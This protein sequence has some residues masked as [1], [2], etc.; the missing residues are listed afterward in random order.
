MTQ[1]MM[2]GLKIHST[3]PEVL[4][5]LDEWMQMRSAPSMPRPARDWLP[6]PQGWLKANADGAFVS[7]DE[8][9]GGGVVL[10]DHN[11]IGRASCRE[12]VYV[13]V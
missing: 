8:I 7:G 11:E 1:E 2:A 10:R 12:R 9:G 4:F 13:L 5:L 6:P 3:Q